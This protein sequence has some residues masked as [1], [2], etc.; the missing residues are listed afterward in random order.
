MQPALSPILPERLGRFEV[1]EALGRSAN[2]DLFGGFD[3]AGERV[4]ALRTLT[5]A[6]VESDPAAARTLARWR[7]EAALSRRVAHPGIVAVYDQ[8]EAAGVFYLATEFIHGQRLDALLE[9][10]IRF[11]TADAVSVAAQLLGAL[12]HAHERGVYHG[13]ISPAEVVLTTRGE[14]KLADFGGAA[15][16]AGNSERERDADGPLDPQADLYAVGTLFFHLLTGRPA[17]TGSPEQIAYRAC[18]GS[19]PLPSDVDPRGACYDAIVRR[20]LARGQDERF[21]SAAE[22]RDALLA[23][24]GGAVRAEV[25]PDVLGREPA[26]GAVGREAVLEP[27]DD[28]LP[29]AQGIEE[30]IDLRGER[31]E[32]RWRIALVGVV[33]LLAV[34]T[35]RSLADWG[36]PQL[37]SRGK[38]PERASPAPIPTPAPPPMTLAAPAAPDAAPPSQRGGDVGI[39]APPRSRTADRSG[40]PSRST[41]A[42]ISPEPPADRSAVVADTPAVARVDVATPSPPSPTEASAA[43]GPRVGFWGDQRIMFEVAT[44]LA[45]KPALSRTQIK[46]ESAGGVVTLRGDVPSAAHATEAVA[47]ARTVAGVRNVH[48]DLRVGQPAYVFPG[49]ISPP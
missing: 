3:P 8:G 42:G 33:V 14:A 20:A 37:L 43:P 10:G 46:V 34:A 28:G 15:A 45:F 24:E 22:F 1:V 39:P 30:P 4:V 26:P 9:S 7:E 23:V 44:R 32:G 5:K 11:S 40:A 2:A 31:S 21:G 29:P 25:S 38:R 36:A 13:A 12:A 49:A 6:R 35:I 16:R 17:F 41:P 27:E 47:A 18:R 48:S 19:T